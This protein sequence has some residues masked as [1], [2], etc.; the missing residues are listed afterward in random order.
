MKNLL[1]LFICLPITYIAMAEE[2]KGQLKVSIQGIDT[3]QGQ[4]YL[5]LLDSQAQY[6]YQA[7]PLQFRRL[8]V[9]DSTPSLTFN[10][11][12]YGRYAVLAFLDENNNRALDTNKLAIPIEKVGLSGINLNHNWAPTFH[13]SAFELD[14]AHQHLVL[15]LTRL[16]Q[17]LDSKL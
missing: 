5:Y 12:S 8:V 11:L 15:Q 10:N 2:H 16:K 3:Q 1:L 17:F 4:L 13:D 9:T 6:D 14:Q 7:P